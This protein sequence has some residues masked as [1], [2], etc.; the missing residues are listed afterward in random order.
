[1]PSSINR[2]AA[3]L[4]S[5]VARQRP[6]DFTGLGVVFYEDLKALPFIGL[7]V[8]SDHQIDLPVTDLGEISTQLAAASS[9]SS[10]WHDGFH[11]VDGRARTL[12]HLAQF[13]SPPIPMPT[14]RADA[15]LA[16][17]ARHMTAMLASQLPGILGVG[18]LAQD[19]EIT[20]FENGMQTLRETTR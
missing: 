5:D 1:M 10:A 4:L 18:L 20:L 15:P 19:G 16:T 8:L 14:E 12:T 2:F 9:A 13:L 3:K 11:F 17:G 7:H 6:D